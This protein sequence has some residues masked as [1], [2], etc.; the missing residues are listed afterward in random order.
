MKIEYVQN[1]WDFA[2]RTMRGAY[3][4]RINIHPKSV[5]IQAGQVINLNAALEEYQRDRKET[6]RKLLSRLQDAYTDLTAQSTTAP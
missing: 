2:N 6:V 1:L 4:N 3:A 5:T